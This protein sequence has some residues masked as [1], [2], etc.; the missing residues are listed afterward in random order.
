ML[1][2][3]GEDDG[4][5]ELYAGVNIL[6]E[7]VRRRIVEI[8]RLHETQ[9]RHERELSKIRE[10]FASI[11]AHE[12]RSPVVGIQWGLAALLQDKRLLG[13]LSKGKRELVNDLLHSA[14]NLSQLISDLLRVAR[15]QRQYQ[16]SVE[17]NAL[18]FNDIAHTVKDRLSS[19][20]KKEQVQVQ[21]DI[22]KQKLPKI[23][24]NPTY[25][26][27]ILWNLVNNSIKYNKAGGWVK[28]KGEVRP[29]ELTV[30]VEDN[31]IGIGEK[32]KGRIF[33]EFYR[34]RNRETREIEGTGLGL[35]ITKTLLERMGGE[36]RV[37][38]QKGKGSTFSFSLPLVDKKR[39]IPANRS[40]I[41]HQVGLTAE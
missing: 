9:I 32:E 2:I 23:F 17:S 39:T 29:K 12:L 20:A 35:F 7:V 4:F 36:I 8:E 38:S 41:T 5:Q 3:P 16:E 11:A 18:S 14:E 21:W 37:T 1:R 30:H 24:A 25:A 26:E 31:G 19:L 27:E 13:V 6:L 33:E 22:L 15:L 40:N 10:N 28:I 34:I